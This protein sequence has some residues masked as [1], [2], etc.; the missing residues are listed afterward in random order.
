M[1]WAFC[2]AVIQLRDS[3]VLL[4]AHLDHLGVG[5]PVKASDIYNG[6]DD[7]ASGTTAVL[8]L[9]RVLGAGV[10]LA[11][12]RSLR[13]FR[14]RGTRRAGVNLLSRE[15]PPLPLHKI[16][17]NLNSKCWDAP[18]PPSNLTPCGLPDGSGQ[19]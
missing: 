3:A 10:R 4:S 17:V 14:E 9:A 8:E 1:R 12:D 2:A 16:A 11:A 6:A 13:A 18:I 7:D 15:H 5:K 19:T